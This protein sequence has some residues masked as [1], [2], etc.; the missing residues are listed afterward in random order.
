MCEISALEHKQSETKEH[1]VEIGLV[2]KR[3][4]GSTSG[5]QGHHKPQ[6]LSAQ[7]CQQGRK[8]STHWESISHRVEDL[9]RGVSERH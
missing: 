6:P 3:G 2:S 8:F 7:Q 5:V 4:G 9:E 1:E